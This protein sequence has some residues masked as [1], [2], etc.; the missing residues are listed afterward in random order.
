MSGPVNVTILQSLL[1]PDPDLIAR[2]AAPLWARVGRPLAVTELGWVRALVGE[3]GP[4]ALWN[5]LQE[6]NAVAGFPPRLQA[7][8]LARLFS[9]LLALDEVK[10]QEEQQ[11]PPRLVWTLPTA[12]ISYASRGGTYRE[13]VIELIHQARQQLVLVSPFLDSVGIGRFLS[14][15]MNALLRRVKV[16]VLTHDALNIASFTSRAIEELRQEA[17]R[18]RVNLTV[19]TGEAGSGRDRF[20]HP[21]LHAKLVICD[22]TRILVGSANLTSHAL[23]VNLETGVLLG[24]TAAQEALAVIDGVIDTRCVHLVFCTGSNA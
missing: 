10:G 6:L 12:H 21:L 8:G 3:Q 16:V 15:L 19:Y 4:A 7:P 2:L 23:S 22:H 11:A 13:A 9:H 20:T 14:P 24:S 17:E 1:G 5:A 18:A